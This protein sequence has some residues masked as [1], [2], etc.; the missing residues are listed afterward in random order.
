MQLR[1]DLINTIHYAQ[2]ISPFLHAE[3][4]NT[5]INQRGKYTRDTLIILLCAHTGIINSTRNKLHTAQK[6]YNVR[7][8]ILEIV[9]NEA[10]LID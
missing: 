9:T 5:Y 6:S 8:F 1:S 2:A 3:V 4:H 7:T 10:R